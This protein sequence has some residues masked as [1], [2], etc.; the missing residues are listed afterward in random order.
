M[1]E[2]PSTYRVDEESI[3]QMVQRIVERFHP[4][5]VILFGSHARGTAHQW[6]DVDLLVVLEQTTNSRESAVEI[7]DTLADLCIA[8]DII[9]STPEEIARRGDFP[10]GVL[11]SALREGK[12]LYALSL[13]HI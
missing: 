10:W 9:V 6:S 8:K 4:L 2:M 11:F 13:I 3:D 5:R 7:G 12:V 1:V